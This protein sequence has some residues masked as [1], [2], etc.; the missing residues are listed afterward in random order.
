MKLSTDKRDV[1]K[2][3]EFQT[4]QYGVD[5][6]NLPLL[7]QLLRT[8]L[9]SDLPGSMIRE[10]TSNVIDSHTEAGKPDAIGEVDWIPS[11]KLLGQDCE[12]VIRDFGVGLSPERMSSVYGNYLS[13]TK[14]DDN[15]S[16]GG[17]GLG[18][19]VPFAYTDSFTVQ[20]V[21][22]GMQYRYL[23]YI[24][25]SQLG[26]I[27]LMATSKVNLINQTE[28]IIPI[29]DEQK[30]YPIFQ[31]AVTAQL[32]YFKT[33]KYSGFTQPD[34]E[35]KFEDEICILKAVPPIKELHVVL[36]NVAYEIDHQALG[37]HP[38]DWE[39]NGYNTCGL[40]L[41]FGIGELQ[42]TMS[43]ENLF[44]NDA[45]KK[46]VLEKIALAR[47][48]VR[49][50]INKELADT[51][52]YGKWFG[53]VSSART[54]SF[55]S[56]W[57]FAQVKGKAEMNYD[58]V[59]LP[60][61]T[62]HTDWFAGHNIRKVVP[63]KAHGWQKRSGPDPIYDAIK[64]ED[65]D[66]ATMPVYQL[67]RNLNGAA[68]LFLFR[69]HP[70]GFLA[71]G[72][73][74]KPEE[75]HLQAYYQATQK[76]KSTLPDFD[77]IDVPDDAPDNMDDERARQYRELVKQRKLMGKFTAKRL[78]QD[79]DVTN[80]Y[81]TSFSYNMFEGKFEDM[82][83]H[84]IIYGFAEDHKKLTKAAALLSYSAEHWAR[85]DF[86]R[87]GPH[88]KPITI[89]K[90]G[91]N[92]E[93]QFYAMPHSY[94]VDEVLMLQTP[95]NEVFAA[96]TTAIKIKPYI[97]LYHSLEY[98]SE[99]NGDMCN[100][101]KSVHQ[102]VENFTRFDRCQSASLENYIL[103][104]N[105]ENLNQEFENDWQDIQDY[106]NG[107]ELLKTV[108]FALHSN[109]HYYKSGKDRTEGTS[110]TYI[111]NW[112]HQSQVFIID[113]LLSKGKSVDGYEKDS[114]PVRIQ[115]EL[116]TEYNN[117]EDVVPLLELQEELTDKTN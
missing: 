71:V 44:W 81:E 31:K 12:L 33:I 105:N 79:H 26:A 68:C 7:F 111:R 69:N 113:Y 63:Y 92:Y 77:A 19:K 49:G 103:T 114:I 22:N 35:I 109:Q 67:S 101:Y 1:T 48:T 73:L 5:A 108:N 23:C 42:P 54:N 100:K 97:H 91:Q 36:G 78:R 2:S 38:I 29:K 53:Y 70:D 45:T 115:S 58:G 112:V 37:I 90:I 117:V 13:S 94:H 75:A 83:D 88:A 57:S 51:T 59:T 47:K 40:G 80:N 25:E 9:Y 89:L 102:F 24:D 93:K 56:Q 84:T 46:K 16:I 32:G 106:Y 17:F 116:L 43:R 61:L 6:S 62:K 98:F 39:Y 72:E 110:A 86:P 30:D 65:S 41:K 21:Y 87:L 52:D 3:Q 50:Q 14:R 74:G 95:L 107:A 10:L 20:T 55:T 85:F 82:K 15:T 18:S 96:I 99:I 34:P 11:S 8:N 76:W 64:P 66:F 28:I 104:K 27:S 60:I 4:Q